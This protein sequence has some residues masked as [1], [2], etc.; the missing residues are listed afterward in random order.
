MTTMQSNPWER[1]AEAMLDHDPEERN[2][3]LLACHQTRQEE[4]L[5][6]AIRI[7]LEEESPE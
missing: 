2:S 5:A 4:H 3:A 7:V 6:H 1:L